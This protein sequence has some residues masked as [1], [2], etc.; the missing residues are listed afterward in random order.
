MSNRTLYRMFQETAARCGS[1]PAFGT[2]PSRNSD[3]TYLTYNET[4]Q[5]VKDLARGLDALGLKRGDTLALLSEN[6]TE[7]ALV[8]LASHLLGLVIVALHYA[9]S[10]AGG[11]HH[12]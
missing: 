5:K 2:R 12:S 1:S 7:W 3:Y 10:S 6:R 11:L 8:D 4:A 9:T